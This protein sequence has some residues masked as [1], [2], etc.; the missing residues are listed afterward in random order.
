MRTLIVEDDFTCRL[1]LQA[2]LARYGECHAVV[3]GQEAVDAFRI[4]QQTGNNYDLI[5]ID[6]MMPEMD[7][8]TALKHIRKLEESEGTLS[9][10][11]AKV[12]MITALDDLSRSIPSNCSIS[13]KRWRWSRDLWRFFRT[14]AG[15]CAY[16]TP[17][18]H[19]LIVRI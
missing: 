2:F 9:S 5:C 4:A 10:S 12:I 14:T 3:N 6:I 8:Q 18:R 13:L 17:L 7:G 1:F 19:R 15:P 11:G 16:F